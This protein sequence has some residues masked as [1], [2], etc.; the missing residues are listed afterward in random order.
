MFGVGFGQ[1]LRRRMVGLKLCDC[2]LVCDLWL[3]KPLAT[4]I[5]K[6]YETLIRLSKHKN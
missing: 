2:L 5:D 6:L 1:Q 4:F 3:V